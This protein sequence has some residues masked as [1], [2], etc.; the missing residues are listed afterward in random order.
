MGYNIGDIINIPHCG[1]GK[2]INTVVVPPSSWHKE[3]LRYT[4]E[5]ITDAKGF[6]I[7]NCVKFRRRFLID[8][9]PILEV[10]PIPKRRWLM[11]KK[12]L[13]VENKLQN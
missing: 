8:G 4:L 3:M 9:L 2:V 11:H 1:V 5:M 13:N 6:E 10:A 7:Y 12:E